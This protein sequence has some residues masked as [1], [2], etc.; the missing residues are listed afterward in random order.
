MDHQTNTASD[1]LQT[2]CKA[3]MDDF[4][5]IATKYKKP[6][7][8]LQKRVAP[9]EFIYIGTAFHATLVYH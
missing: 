7:V 2:R 8:M 3:A 6:F 4:V 1:S 9:V 5:E